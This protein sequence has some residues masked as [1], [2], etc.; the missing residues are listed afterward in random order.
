MG[1]C[2]RDSHLSPVQVLAKA[3]LCT[4]LL[5]KSSR[6]RLWRVLRSPTCTHQQHSVCSVLPNLRHDSSCIW[7]YGL[8]P[9]LCY[10]LA[11]QM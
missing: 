2:A 11:A 1:L 8:V 6:L 4:R 5:L 10:V 3:Q 7:C 9:H